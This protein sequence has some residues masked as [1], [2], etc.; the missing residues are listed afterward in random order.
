MK[1]N[2]FNVLK[3]F[4]EYL[5]PFK[6]SIIILIITAT[7]AIPVSLISPKM[8]QILLDE[9]IYNSKT[10]LLTYVILGLLIV[11]IFRLILD[12]LNLHFGNKLLNGFTYKLR[13]SLWDRITGTLYANIDKRNTGELKMRLVDD[14][15]AVG[16]FIKDQIVDYIFNIILTL[17]SLCIIISID[18]TMT[19]Y[20]IWIIPLMFYINYLIA[21]GSKKVNEEIRKVS[22]KYYT[23]THNSLQLWRE[24]K[25]QCTEDIFIKK[26]RKYR[27]KLAILGYKNIRYW[28]YM[29][30]IN[31]FKANYLSKVFIY[32]VGVFFIIK[33]DVSVGSVIMFGEIFEMM[34]NA[35]DTVNIRNASIKSNAPYYMRIIDTMQFPQEEKDDAKNFSFNNNIDIN[36]SAF[37]Y[38]ETEKKVLHDINFNIK[39][40]DFISIIGESGCGKTTLLKLLLGLYSAEGKENEDGIK[41][42]NVGMTKILKSDLYKH[43]GVVMQ[44]SFLFNMSIKE[45]IMISNENATES[46]LEEACRKSD[47]YSFIISL[48]EGFDTVI[49]ERGVKL[50]GGQK[51][52]I[53]IAR[54][55]LKKPELIIFDEATSS[56][57][58]LSEDVVYEAV[59]NIA[60]DTTVIVVSH[61]PS[62]V[63]RSRTIIIMENGCIVKIGSKEALSVENE[64]Y[65]TMLE[66]AGMC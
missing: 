11:Y 16:S 36:F 30:V 27:D 4:K 63:L 55:L 44:D 32:I 18:F 28:F 17:V 53:C 2:R 64:F 26:F 47:I 43:I 39:K 5:S 60:R 50:S 12:S 61:K 15:D 3:N 14:V 35:I 13:M 37:S 65:K 19:L 31:D 51:Q 48:P 10:E 49:G 59:N 21:K 56:L 23:S 66:G 46:D 6:F 40:G 1:I 34:F 33:G 20:C 38:P 8:F 45:N 25:I 42:D 7:L 29:E 41:Y 58:K 22:Q 52:R 62:A 54:A 9:V 24:I 57:D